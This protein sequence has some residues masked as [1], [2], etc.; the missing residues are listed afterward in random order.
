MTTSNR[1]SGSPASSASSPS[2]IAVSG[3]SSAGLSTTAFPAASAGAKPHAAIVIGKFQGTMIPTTPYGSWNVMSMPPATGI[4]C[5][6]SRSGAPG[7]V[8]QHLGDV[9]RLP[10]GRVDRMPGV[11]HLE[12]RELLDVG[13]DDPR[14]GAQRVRARE[15]SKGCPRPLGGDCARDRG[16]DLADARARHLADRCGGRRVDHGERAGHDIAPEFMRVSGIER[17]RSHESGEQPAVFEVLLGMPL[18]AEHVSV[19]GGLERLR[20]SVVGA[21]GHDEAIAELVDALVVVAV[22]VEVVLSPTS[23]ARA[24]PSLD[25]DGVGREDAAADPEPLGAQRLGQ[26]LMQR[27]AARHVHELEAA[28]DGEHRDPPLVGPA[29]QSELP[30]VAVRSR[31]VGEGMPL[32]PVEL[33]LDVLAARQDQP[34]QAVEHDGCRQ[35]GVRL[36]RKEHRDAARC[37]HGIEVHVRQECR[38]HVPHPLLGLL[39]VRRQTDDRRTAVRRP[40]VVRVV[41]N[42]GS[43]PSPSRRRRRPRPRSAPD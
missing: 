8:V 6:A 20:E 28:A 37:R 16:I 23:A 32:C 34:V 22:H 4:C 31:V 7:V 41:R 39:E 14:E 35:F 25:L 13:L 9:R 29:E 40:D 2:R 11:E 36:R 5:P 3:V 42:H 21:R 10:P 43:A 19:A 24:V 17:C 12:Q 38:L 1:P 27:A 26:V 18:D 30:G 15:R 33:G